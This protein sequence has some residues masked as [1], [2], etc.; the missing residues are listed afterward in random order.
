MAAIQSLN[1]CLEPFDSGLILSEDRPPFCSSE[2]VPASKRHLSLFT[3]AENLSQRSF[4]PDCDGV[5]TFRNRQSPPLPGTTMPV[6]AAR[7]L[8]ARRAEL[9]GVACPSSSSPA[10][11]A[12]SADRP[13]VA[14]Q[15]G[16]L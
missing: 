4:S 13:P 11:A 6:I 12:S 16:C 15:T 14:W 5:H 9:I 10:A 3:S 2:F 8:H 1:R 7:A